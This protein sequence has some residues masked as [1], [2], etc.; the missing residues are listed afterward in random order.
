VISGGLGK[1]RGWAKSS[2]RRPWLNS[3][4][5]QRRPLPP[6]GE[7]WRRCESAVNY[8]SISRN[9]RQT[10]R[11]DANAGPPLTIAPDRSSRLPRRERAPARLRDRNPACDRDRALASFRKSRRQWR[12]VS[13]FRPLLSRRLEARILRYWLYSPNPITPL[14][15]E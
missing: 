12:D 7:A 4:E 2:A 1:S 10:R 6:L 3:I 8:N 9:A 13:P 14:S 11:R 15:P 5:T